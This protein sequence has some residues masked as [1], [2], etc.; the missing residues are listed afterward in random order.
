MRTVLA[1]PNAAAWLNGSGIHPGSSMSQ[2]GLLL[3]AK[4]L[5]AWTAPAEVSP[6]VERKLKAGCEARRNGHLSR[7]PGR[8]H[9]DYP[10]ESG[11][12]I[13]PDSITSEQRLG[14]PGAQDLIAW[15]L[16]ET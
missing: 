15:P 7:T 11:S 8:D 9:R 6:L 2:R 13:H 16:G 10:G 4:D 3:G 5:I 12:G 14:S 1:P